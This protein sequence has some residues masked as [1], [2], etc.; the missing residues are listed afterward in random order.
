MSNT[1]RWQTRGWGRAKRAPPP[2]ALAGGRTV[3]GTI[4][5]KTRHPHRTKLAAARSGA[6][7]F[8]RRMCCVFARGF[9]KLRL[10]ISSKVFFCVRP[11]PDFIRL[12]S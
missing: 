9:A 11:Q 4:I 10:N 2:F 7:N 5:A 6:A 3:D 12:A 8:G 1:P